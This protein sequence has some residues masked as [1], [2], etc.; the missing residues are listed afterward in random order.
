MAYARMS[1]D[2]DDVSTLYTTLALPK[3]S[4]SIRI[5]DV[6]SAS[7]SEDGPLQCGLRVINLDSE[8]CP[9][10][11]AL[12]YVWGIKTAGSYCIS[13]N[14]SSLAITPNC[15]SAL[16][17]LRKKLGKFT[18]WIDAIC[19]NQY[20]EGEKMRQIQLMGDIYSNAETVYIWLG[21]SNP[22]TTRAMT[23]LKSA[24]Y[25]KYFFSKDESTEHELLLE[26]DKDSI[27]FFESQ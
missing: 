20:D 1:I 4:R 21:D 22:A 9:P 6:Y 3:D 19:I 12:S 25:L 7:S 8:N 18:I 16:R 5:L 17:H 26:F 2:T 14:S 10:F 11:T 13:C 24:G 15:Y 23:Y 27:P